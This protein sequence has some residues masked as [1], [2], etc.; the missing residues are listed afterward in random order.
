VLL[1]VTEV[2]PIVQAF[3]FYR[4]GRNEIL[5][6]LFPWKKGS[7]ELEPLILTESLLTISIR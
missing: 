3:S 4:A 7:R 2:V 1:R 6:G 5:A